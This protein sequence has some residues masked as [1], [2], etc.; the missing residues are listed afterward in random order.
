MPV[1]K[2][3]AVKRTPARTPTRTP[4]RAGTAAPAPTRTSIREIVDPRDPA[5]REAYA[6]LAR[7]FARE[8]RVLLSS[9]TGSLR[10]GAQGLLSDVAWHLLVAEQ[11]GHV[12]GIASG[13]YLGNVNVGVIG[14]LAISPLVRAGGLGTRLRRRLRTHFSRDA[15][16]ITKAPLDAIIGEV[17]PSNRWLRTLASREGVIVLDFPYFQPR[18]Y[19]GDAAS[20]FVLYYESL[21]RIRQRLPASELR[22]LLYAIWRRVYRVPRPLERPAFR[23]MMKALERRRTIGSLDLSRMESRDH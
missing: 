1:R 8:E 2:S 13:T 19:E 22:R 11:G 21:S 4:T 14:Y 5:L 12:V 23:A 15:M 9:W 18:L 6:L 20:P 3:A 16:R 7:S 17:S 10:E